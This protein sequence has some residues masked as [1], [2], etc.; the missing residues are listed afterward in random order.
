[1]SAHLS[2]GGRTDET[3]DSAA[4][5]ALDLAAIRLIPRV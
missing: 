4:E 2:F 1:M 5:R 3:S